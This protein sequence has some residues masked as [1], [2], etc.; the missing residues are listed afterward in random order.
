MLFGSGIPALFPLT[1][2]ILFEMYWIDKI[3]IFTICQK[4]VAFDESLS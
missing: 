4:P 3:K 1:T 2:I